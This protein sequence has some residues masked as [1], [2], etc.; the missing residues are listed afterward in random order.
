MDKVIIS[1]LHVRG[2]IGIHPWER[3][4]PQDILINIVLF[5]DLRKAGETDDIEDCINYQ[6]IAENL[7]AHA[8]KAKRLTVEALAADIADLCLRVNGVERVR[9]RVEKPDAI[10]F[11]R[12]VGVEI[13]RSRSA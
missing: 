5:A 11:A 10:K 3:E 9:V 7:R 12:T 2:I 4:R 6:T 8:E 13:E 1:D